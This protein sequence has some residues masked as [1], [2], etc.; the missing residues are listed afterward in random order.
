MRYNAKKSLRMN[1]TKIVNPIF[2]R[3]MKAI[4]RYATNTAQIQEK[5]LRQLIQEAKTRN[6][7]RLINT[8]QYIL[9]KISPD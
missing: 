3:R 7:E 6:G 4:D 8:I 5:I 2:V 1:L 9:M